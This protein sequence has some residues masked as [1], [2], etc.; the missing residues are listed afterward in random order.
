M[1]SNFYGAIA[2]IGGAAG[3]LDAIDGTDLA[4]GDGAYVIT[5][6]GFYIYYLNASSGAAESSPDVISPDDNA[7]NKRWILQASTKFYIPDTDSSNK[8]QLKWNEDDATNRVLN[9]KV[10]T[11]NRTLDLAE[12]LT[13]LDGAAIKFYA[14]SLAS[15]SLPASG[16]VATLSKVTIDI[17]G[18]SIDGTPIGAA[19]KATGNFSYVDIDGGVINA[20]VATI[21]T[22]DINGGTIDDTV[23]GAS[24]KATGNFSYVDIN[25]G[26]A[27]IAIATLGTATITTVDINGGTINASNATIADAVLTTADIN[28]GTVDGVEINDSVIGAA[29]KA[30]GNFS[31]VDIDG[32]VINASV[33]TFTSM[34][35][36]GTTGG[37]NRRLVEA[38]T[39][40]LATG[41]TAIITLGIPAASNILGAQLRVDT[42]ITGATT[43][44]AAFSG[45]NTAAICATEATAQNTKV[46][47][48]S[49]GLATGTTNITITATGP[50]FT[51]GVIRAIAYYEDF[52]TMDSL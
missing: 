47:S 1:A 45:G 31:Y 19:T 46:N 9:F 22:V 38:V 39:A 26:T 32:G 23:I 35:I 25:D 21:G 15:L 13:V 44:S 52:V 24:T 49:G 40:T 4:T 42:K 33:A 2:L 41:S 37:Y 16:S 3:A 10:N 51:A 8:L 17:D 14:A 50:N 12:D 6:T 43:W 48:F 20:S 7:G 36:K 28:G 27:N 18:G 34:A 30:T 29:T 11:G 5:A